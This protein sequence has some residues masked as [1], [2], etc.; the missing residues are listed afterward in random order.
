MRFFYDL[1][2]HERGPEQPIDLISLAM[3]AE[4]G[5][6]Y[7]AQHTGFD[8]RAAKQNEWLA[9]HVLAQLSICPA[10]R[11]F[12]ARER[13]KPADILEM[14][15]M[16]HHIG[17]LDEDEGGAEGRCTHNDCPWRSR[18]QLAADL[19]AFANPAVY[20]RP[21]LW[22]Y[23]GAYDH[24]V[25]MQIFGTMMDKPEGWPMWSHDLKQ[26]CADLGD[27]PLPEQGAGEHNALVDARWNRAT[28]DFLQ[29]QQ[30]M[31]NLL[32]IERG[33]QSYADAL[34]QVMAEM[35]GKVRLTHTSPLI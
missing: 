31:H 32:L 2:F 3:V 15:W 21:E 9:E 12:V 8:L 7:I 35:V 20:G 10:T 24:V 13:L 16:D 30:R 25:L 22:A 27:P 28:Y 4:D 1:E 26:L 17:P 11:A 29:Q 6:E 23:Y 34:Q 18:A 5:R 19:V 14:D 33:A